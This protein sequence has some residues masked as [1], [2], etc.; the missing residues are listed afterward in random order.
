MES[1]GPGPCHTLGF[2]PME[3]RADV[4]ASLAAGL[5]DEPGFQIGQ[6]NIILPS[7][8]AAGGP[9]AAPIIRAI[10]QQSA[11]AG[12]A[13]LGNGD[14]LAFGRGGIKARRLPSPHGRPARNMHA[15]TR[16]GGSIDSRPRQE[17]P[18][19]GRRTSRLRRPLLEPIADGAVPDLTI[20][21]L[22]ENMV[23]CRLQRGVVGYDKSTPNRGV[24]PYL[25]GQL[26]RNF[27]RLIFER[28][29]KGAQRAASVV[30]SEGPAAGGGVWF[31]AVDPGVPLG[32]GLLSTCV[33]FHGPHVRTA[34]TRMNATA[35]TANLRNLIKLSRS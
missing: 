26:A 23:T 33:I 31:S 7:V 34:T 22:G 9:V 17:S 3:I 16:L 14:L 25:H 6:P 28:L 29:I 21:H 12:S 10:N 27:E 30:V 20:P 11:N 1:I 19:F 35:T 18:Y 15:K 4:G 24:L 8:A 32:P 5:A 2:F 13:H